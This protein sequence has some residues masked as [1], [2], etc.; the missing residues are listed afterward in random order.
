MSDESQLQVTPNTGDTALSL[1]KGRSGLIARGRQDAATLAL[2]IP[3]AAEETAKVLIPEGVCNKCGERKE[4]VLADCVCG[5]CRDGLDKEWAHV[6][7]TNWVLVAV[8]AHPLDRLVSKT[9]VAEGKPPRPDS[10]LRY[11]YRNTTYTQMKSHWATCD[12]RMG[13]IVDRATPEDETQMR[14]VC[15]RS[16]RPDG[17]A[18]S[19]IQE[20]GYADRP[21]SHEDFAVGPFGGWPLSRLVFIRPAS[22]EDVVKHDAKR[23]W[24][25]DV[26]DAAL[27][28]LPV[29]E[30]HAFAL[31]L[32]SGRTHHDETSWS[33]WEMALVS[34]A[35]ETECPFRIHPTDWWYL[36]GHRFVSS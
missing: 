25:Q 1:S 35:S 19:D 34:A 29:D 24:Y 12:A 2:Q 20:I 8:K 17:P 11:V 21:T 32:S 13:L 36:P 15:G 33:R 16:K 3:R 7:A 31:K 6:A 14:S 9:L 26:Y 23:R 22:P 30:R 27:L 18:S 10:L 4:L 5:S 28:K